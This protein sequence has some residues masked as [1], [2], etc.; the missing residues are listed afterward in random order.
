[1]TQVSKSF[2][3]CLRMRGDYKENQVT[4]FLTE[5][6]NYVIGVNANIKP[7]QSFNK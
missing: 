6:Y 2:N 5:M 1:M 4:V 3:E 7:D